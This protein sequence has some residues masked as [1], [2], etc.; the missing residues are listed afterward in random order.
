MRKTRRQV[1][2][3]G[4]AVALALCP[5][6]ASAQEAIAIEELV[7]TAR[8]R[9]E[10]LRDVPAAVT[11]I[12][13]EQRETLVLDRTDDYLRQ[14]PSAT[15]VT[16]GPEYLNDITIRGQGGGRLAF[17]ETA[18]GIFR[19]GMYSAGGGFGGRSISRMDLFDVKRVEVLR[20]PQGALFGRN[21]VG[22]AI[23]IVSNQP[24]DRPGGRFTARYSDPE[25]TDLE[26]VL[27][28][29]VNEQLGFRI[30]GLFSE[31]KDGFIHNSD[32]GQAVD[33]QFYEGFRVIAEARPTDALELSLAYEYSDSEAPS[34]TSLGQRATRI[35]GRPLDTSPFTR[36][37]MN[38][39]GVSNISEHNLVFAAV[40]D[41]GRADLSVKASRTE[42]DGG[43]ANEDGDHFNG[44][45]GIDVAPGT[46]VLFQD[47]A[48]FQDEDFEQT[49]VQA[50][51]ASSGDERLSWLIGAEVISSESRVD[52]EAKLCPAYTGTAQALTPGCI[53]GAA[54][55]FTPA[56]APA[57][58]LSL[59]ARTSARLGVNRDQFT[60]ELD[61]YSIFGS[62][63][64]RLTDTLTFGAELRVQTDEKSFTLA[65]WSQDPL[66]Y[67]G[68]GAAP[69]GLMPPLTADPDGAGPL[70][71]SPIQFCPPTLAAPQC[72]AGLET[73]R[74]AAD[75]KWT[76]WTPAATLRWT[77]APGQ[78]AYARFATGYR[79]GGFN[80]NLAPN[81]VRSQLAA[82]LLYDPENA[83]S[84][85][86]GWKGSL[87]G[88]FLTGEAAAF[89]VW[90]NEVQVASAPSATS[91]GFVLQN[92]GDAHVYG[93]EAELRR[94]QP[95]GPGRLN[96]SLSYS[97]QRG[98]FEAGATSLSDL[99]E[100][101]TPELVDLNG[102]KVPRLR[103]YQVT[104]NLTYSQPLTAG[105]TGFVSVSGQFADGGFQNPPNTISYPGY[106]LVDGR[107]GV[108]GQGWRL[109]AFG[110]NLGDEVYVLNNVS[111]NNYWSQPRV[112]GVELTLRR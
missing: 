17:S 41:L 4:A 3:S 49:A 43:R 24:G 67:F 93:F 31:Q 87:F 66:V 22:G 71:A 28:L 91:R 6:I 111:G 110:R 81:T 19:D 53:V 78:N 101:G 44:N 52:T 16:S 23:N 1:F 14:V 105:L 46:A 59:T 76:V 109:S 25:R 72:A 40:Y 85:E 11:A 61:S 48:G 98:E 13:E 65:R 8:K 20:G 50:Y 58:L 92:S 30:G 97:M 83:Y 107:I 104:L 96:A 73:A 108:F 26:A 99:N 86:A 94:V 38:R 75:R 62:V 74:V 60:E 5:V 51:L 10:V 95:L 35:D 55:Q 103:D 36:S 47:T 100:D 33:K 57:S 37:D 82:G 89:Y 69:A 34:F 29:P 84:Y 39:L 2:L 80:T 7:I 102:R 56:T 9:E 15:L 90:T 88:G 42:R 54:G 68:S 21:S 45:T 77:F 12:S 27:D 18:T 63:E 112:L 64:Y 79:P 106:S 32:T 70:P